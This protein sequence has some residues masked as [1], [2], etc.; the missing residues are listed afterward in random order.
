M[1]LCD[2]RRNIPQSVPSKGEDQPPFIPIDCPRCGT[3]HNLH[4]DCVAAVKGENFR[5]NE[6]HISRLDVKVDR[7]YPVDAGLNL[8]GVSLETRFAGWPNL[9]H[10]PPV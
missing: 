7:D 10:L 8:D 2:P 5:F 4:G 3:T 9:P 6:L 1:N